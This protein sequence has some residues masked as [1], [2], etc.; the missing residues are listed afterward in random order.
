M[1]E[2][3]QPPGVPVQPPH[4]LVV[5]W[6]KDEYILFIVGVVIGG[7]LLAW[8]RWW[9]RKALREEKSAQGL[10]LEVRSARTLVT[11]GV[12]LI[13]ASVVY[14]FGQSLIGRLLSK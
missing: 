11:T 6:A 7:V 12:F 5:A 10:L 1:P 13:A 2:R 8:G 4:P 3:V 9:L 14:L